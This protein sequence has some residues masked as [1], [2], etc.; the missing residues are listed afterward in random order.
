MLSISRR[1]RQKNNAWLPAIQS[2]SSSV[3]L[4]GPSPSDLL[5]ARNTAPVE[6]LKNHCRRVETDP[7]IE[8]IATKTSYLLGKRHFQGLPF[9]YRSSTSISVI[10]RP[11]ELWTMLKGIARASEFMRLTATTRH[12][13]HFHELKMTNQ[14]EQWSFDLNNHDD[15]WSKK[16]QQRFAAVF[17]ISVVKESSSLVTYLACRAW[18]ASSPPLTNQQL[19]CVVELPSASRFKPLRWILN[20]FTPP[21]SSPG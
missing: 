1:R 17:K 12:C 20:K 15:S 16:K 18:V 9:K 7:W 21:P 4:N 5:I 8:N 11:L 13:L 6:I 10:A 2:Y 3:S 19:Q 14:R